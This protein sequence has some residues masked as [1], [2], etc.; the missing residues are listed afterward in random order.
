MLGSNA[1]PSKLAAIKKHGLRT[2]SEDEFLELIATRVVNVGGSSGKGQ[3]LD[4]KT[5]KK[6]EKE[7]EAVRKGAEELEA[8]ERK[9]KKKEGSR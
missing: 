3:G 7:A 9:A 8:R 4:T 1:G 2:L 5:R 6:M